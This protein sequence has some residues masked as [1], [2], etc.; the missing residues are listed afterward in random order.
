M[1]KL[2]ISKYW[3]IRNDKWTTYIN[4]HLH[5]LIGV[6]RVML[7]KPLQYDEKYY[8]DSGEYKLTS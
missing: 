4:Y 1:V 6:L 7:R 5:N 3:I 8:T 2:F